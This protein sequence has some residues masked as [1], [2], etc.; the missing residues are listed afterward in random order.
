MARATALPSAGFTGPT[1]FIAPGYPTL[2]AAVFLVF[3]S[4]S[5]A[6]A[7]AIM[8]LQTGISVLTIWWMMEVARETLGFRTAVLAGSF[9]AI[10][11][12]LL[13]IPTIFW[14]TSISACA[15]VGTIAFALRARRK[16][17]IATWMLM[18]SCSALIA[19][20][21]PALLPSLLAMMGWL[22]WQTRQVSRSAPLLGLLALVLVFSPWP[23]RN[24]YRFHA[25]IPM[26]STVG[27]ELWMGNRPGATGYLDESLFPYYNHQELASYVAMG[28][29]AY[30]RDKSQQAWAY[31]SAHPGTFLNLSVRRCFRFWMGTGS[32]GGSP[33]FVLHAVT[34]TLLGAIGLLLLYRKAHAPL[35]G[36]DRPAPAAVSASLLH[37]SCGV[38]LSPQHRSAD[39]DPGGV[40]SRA[41][42]RDLVAPAAV[43]P[44]RRSL[45]H[46]LNSP[47]SAPDGYDR[48]E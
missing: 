22:A 26:R 35:R 19:L 5:F 11:L 30:T 4:Y 40:C 16:P 47:S 39:D 6:S 12:P 1:A 7:I 17:T 10:S 3:G 44:E 27:F 31:I 38:P 46:N 33:I 32:A 41:A 28:E 29:L 9:W 23:I 8:V 2:I 36:L 14:E 48:L 13:W 20:V 25:F 42:R 43:D 24:A 18:G 45:L 37:H 15:I 34:T 21:N